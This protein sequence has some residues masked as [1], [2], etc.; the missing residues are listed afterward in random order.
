[1]GRCATFQEVAKAND[2]DIDPSATQVGVDV[3]R[4]GEWLVEFSFLHEPE[5]HQHLA[6]VPATVCKQGEGEG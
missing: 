3:F 4:S 2:V 5:R 1:M 6:H